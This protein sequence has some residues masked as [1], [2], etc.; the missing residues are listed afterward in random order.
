MLVKKAHIV[1]RKKLII[2]KKNFTMD[3]QYALVVA[4]SDFYS[5]TDVLFQP[6]MYCRKKKIQGC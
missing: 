5:H 2:S 6:S 1:N 3:S 4:K